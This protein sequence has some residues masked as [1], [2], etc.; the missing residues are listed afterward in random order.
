MKGWRSGI[1]R[2]E[3]CDAWWPT[4][5]WRRA[6]SVDWRSGEAIEKLLAGHHGT[7]HHWAITNAD[8][9][10]WVLV[11]LRHGEPRNH[12]GKSNDNWRNLEKL[13]FRESL[14]FGFWFN[15]TI[16]LVVWLFALQGKTDDWALIRNEALLYFS[17]DGKYVSSSRL[18]S[19]L[20]AETA[21]EIVGTNWGG[22]WYTFLTHWLFGM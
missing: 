10:S 13:T 4:G 22:F 12:K 14:E 20:R 9:T 21:T 11:E 16:L 2:I 19:N 8:N 5:S 15:I 6:R 17:F 18:D 7:C 1:G 3:S